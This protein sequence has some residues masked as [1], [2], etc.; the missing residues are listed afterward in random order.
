LFRIYASLNWNSDVESSFNTPIIRE[1]LAKRKFQHIL[2]LFIFDLLF[3][4]LFNLLKSTLFNLFKWIERLSPLCQYSGSMHISTFRWKLSLT[5]CLWR[6]WSSLSIRTVSR[7]FILYWGLCQLKHI[8]I[9]ICR[10][11]FDIFGLL[12]FEIFLHFETLEAHL[13]WIFLFPLFIWWAL[14]NRS[15]NLLKWSFLSKIVQFLHLVLN[16]WI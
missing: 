13:L 16:F 1:R 2:L 5:L 12:M 10:L 11:R 4:V 6:A 3:F 8:N 14:L 9:G 15:R 7:F